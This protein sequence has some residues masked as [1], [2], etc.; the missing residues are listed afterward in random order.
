MTA[1]ISADQQYR[2]QLTRNMDDL[3]AQMGAPRL[4]FLMLNPSTA[5]AALDDP[6]IRRCKGFALRDGY[7]GIVVVNLYALRSTDPSNLWVHDDPVGPDNDRYLVEVASLHPAVVCAWGANAPK[8]RV[9]QVMDLLHQTRARLLCLGTT[10]DGSPR[11]PLYVKGETALMKWDVD[12][13]KRK[14]P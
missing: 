8:E 11:H 4:P 7:S 1:V 2:Y 10:Q 6:T 3:C 12:A 9:L 14:Q 13:W 5:D